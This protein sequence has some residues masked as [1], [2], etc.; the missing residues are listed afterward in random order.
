MLRWSASIILDE[1]IFFIQWDE[2]KVAYN[3]A[4]VKFSVKNDIGTT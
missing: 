2:V 4:A 3:F 1:F